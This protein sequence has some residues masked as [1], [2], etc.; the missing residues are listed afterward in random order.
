MCFYLPTRTDDRAQLI[1]KAYS[2]SLYCKCAGETPSNLSPVW[3]D[4]RREAAAASHSSLLLPA[5]SHLSAVRSACRVFGSYEITLRLCGARRSSSRHISVRGGPHATPFPWTCGNPHAALGGTACRHAMPPLPGRNLSPTIPCGSSC[6]RARRPQ[7][8]ALSQAPAR[9]TRPGVLYS[10]Q[11]SVGGRRPRVRG[12][13]HARPDRFRQV[14]I[15]GRST[16][17]GRDE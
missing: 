4:T 15:P 17:G 8:R 16:P 11:P 9:H 12:E 10:E 14:S 2:R 7:S 13:A 6:V 1:N 5:L 3:G